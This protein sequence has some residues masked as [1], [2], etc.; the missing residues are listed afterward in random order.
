[1]MELI[2]GK[3]ACEFVSKVDVHTVG[4]AYWEALGKNIS[5]QTDGERIIIGTFENF[6]RALASREDRQYIPDNP[7]DLRHQV[8]SFFQNTYFLSGFATMQKLVRLFP[9]FLGGTYSSREDTIQIIGVHFRRQEFMGKAMDDQKG[10]ILIGYISDELQTRCPKDQ[11]GIAT[12]MGI[13]FGQL[14]FE[15][16]VYENTNPHLDSINEAK[17]QPSSS[18]V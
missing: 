17:N 4:D 11:D 10:I 15:Q 9:S 12:Q 13:L 2:V 18:S 8:S 3:K 14:L 16:T 5:S 7:E 1:M 6:R